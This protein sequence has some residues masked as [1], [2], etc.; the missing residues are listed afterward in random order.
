[1]E[2]WNSTE[3]HCA[4]WKL[5]FGI[6]SFFLAFFLFSTITLYLMGV[7]QS[8]MMEKDRDI[9]IGLCKELGR[10]ICFI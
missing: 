7:E 4:S 8:E 9:I 5:A 10:E 2:W 3:L 1:M 6:T